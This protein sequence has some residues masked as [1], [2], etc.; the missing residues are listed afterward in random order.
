[1]YDQVDKRRLSCY[2]YF[3]SFFTSVWTLENTEVTNILKIVVDRNILH[4]MSLQWQ[5]YEV[6]IK[7]SHVRKF[8]SGNIVIK[9]KK[10]MQHASSFPF[11]V[12]WRFH[13]P[14]LL[15][16]I[17]V[18]VGPAAGV[19]QNC[20]CFNPDALLQFSS[21]VTCTL[22]EVASCAIEPIQKVQT[23]SPFVNVG[24]HQ[25]ASSSVQT[26]QAFRQVGDAII[27]LLETDE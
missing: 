12:L 14:N 11:S 7:L 2:L 26:A 17:A 23:V 24:D 18:E 15:P 6:V 13:H 4:H 25:W 3:L 10:V 21:C 9:E 27:F 5:S 16:S 19:K 8:R 20:C 22:L 1:M